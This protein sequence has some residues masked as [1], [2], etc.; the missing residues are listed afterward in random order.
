MAENA[1]FDEIKN[2]SEIIKSDFEK[3][4]KTFKTNHTSH[5][6]K[7]E[8][9]KL[10]EKQHEENVRK[11]TELKIKFTKCQDLQDAADISKKQIELNAL[12]TDLENI[13]SIE[14]IGDITEFSVK[15]EKLIEEF[16]D[17]RIAL[18]A[19]QR[20]NKIARSSTIKS[21]DQ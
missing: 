14:L 1:S 20:A 17:S 21:C 18:V 8:R 2:K 7:R 4:L 13:K 16:K 9:V 12:K 3:L 10:E 11:F 5:T 15:V 19:P 6:E